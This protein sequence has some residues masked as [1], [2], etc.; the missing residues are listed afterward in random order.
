MALPPVVPAL[1]L[2]GRGIGLCGNGI[3]ARPVPVAVDTEDVAV[4]G[5]DVPPD[6]DTVPVAEWFLDLCP[7]AEGE[8]EAEVGGGEEAC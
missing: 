6:P 2:G 8:D 4:A 3:G 7:A 1:G 5:V